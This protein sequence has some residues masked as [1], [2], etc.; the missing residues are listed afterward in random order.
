M[1]RDKEVYNGKKSKRFV[2]CSRRACGSIDFDR[3][4]ASVCAEPVIRKYL[5]KSFIYFP[6]ILY[7]I[8]VT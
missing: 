2:F 6:D 3:L 4:A 7:N 5:S 1:Q 8:G